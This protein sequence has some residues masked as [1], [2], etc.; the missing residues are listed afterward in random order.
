MKKLKM[1]LK[2]LLLG[3]YF[4]VWIDLPLVESASSYRRIYVPYI[5]QLFG[6]K[7]AKTD[8]TD[9]TTDKN[10]GH[11]DK[12]LKEESKGELAESR[13]K[14]TGKENTCIFSSPEVGL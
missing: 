6:D 5:F 14:G 11:S 13:L 7:P 1:D 12:V 8:Q 4:V 3:I 9:R 2:L 10:T